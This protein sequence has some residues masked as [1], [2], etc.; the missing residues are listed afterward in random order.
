MISLPDHKLTRLRF[1]FHWLSSLALY[2]PKIFLK[3]FWCSSTF[4]WHRELLV[5]L[6]YYRCWIFVWRLTVLE[7]Q[8]AQIPWN[9]DA[10]LP[11]QCFWYQFQY[12]HCYWLSKSINFI[13][14][15]LSSW[16]IVGHNNVILFYNKC[17]TYPQW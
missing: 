15:Q 14:L 17:S 2:V 7:D 5:E 12:H 4:Y 13:S 8:I 1:P 3:H 6:C 16:P 9:T 10:I 11:S